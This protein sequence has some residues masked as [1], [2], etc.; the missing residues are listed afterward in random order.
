MSIEVRTM[1]EED[2]D[3][4][5]NVRVD[6]YHQPASAMNDNRHLF[7]LSE[8][9]CLF[10]DGVMKATGRVYPFR[11]R[12]HGQW[13][14]MGGVA[15]IAT[16][17]E[18]R[19]RGFIRRIMS[20]IFQE[21]REK[22]VPLATLYPSVYAFYRK[23]GYEIVSEKR[24]ITVA[25]APQLIVEPRQKGKIRRGT[26]ADHERVRELYERKAALTQGYLDRNEA[27]WRDRIL[28]VPYMNEPRRLYLWHDENG[29][30]QAYLLLDPISD[31]GKIRI[32][33][34]VSLTADGIAALLTLMTQD[35]L[36]KEWILETELEFPMPTLLHNPRVETAVT[37]SFMARIVDVQT[38]WRTVAPVARSG[39]AVLGVEDAMCEWNNGAWELT[40]ENGRG[41]VQAAGDR[42][43]VQA[44]G[45]ISV[46][47]QLFYG[48]LTLDQAIFSGKLTIYDETILPFLSRLW[49]T[50]KKPMMIDAF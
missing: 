49:A 11:Q 2:W 39:R 44:S 32:K 24:T 10:E 30:A 17:L 36:L 31:D 9:R 34:L 3:G 38:A 29:A 15:S 35:N 43:A 16:C 48:Y 13:L 8:M 12:L 28:R 41:H 45:D 23:F 18:D 19:G 22:G 1:R 46:W 42:N 5:V 6:S 26:E 21:L 27:M 37:P 33:E 14:E 50:D 47:T 40:V 20:E 4:F 25:N 7:D